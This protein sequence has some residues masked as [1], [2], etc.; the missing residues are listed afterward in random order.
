LIAPSIEEL[1]TKLAYRAKESVRLAGTDLLDE[2][3]H[4]YA[5]HAG[6]AVELLLRAVLAK[7]HPTLIA[8][9]TSNFDSLLIL[10]GQ[11]QYA[12]PQSRV[13]PSLAQHEKALRSLLDIRNGAIHYVDSES[14]VANNTLRGV[15]GLI[16]IVAPLLSV[17]SDEILVEYGE[18][19]AAHADALNSEAAK[20]ALRKLLAARSLY[21]I[22]FQNRAAVT[23]NEIEPLFRP[24]REAKGR[25]A[26]RCPACRHDGTLEYDVERELEIE[27]E[28]RTELVA[29]GIPARIERDN[30]D[31]AAV[32]PA[33]YAALFPDDDGGTH[34]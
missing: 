19:F 30:E 22:R 5:V 11:R 2:Q 13:A 12:S 15:F 26:R 3:W 34:S 10:V 24:F 20:R 7:L 28:T 32:D 29:A 6:G 4:H 17:T 33:Y 1:P 25:R 21:T 9:P 8:A 14:A 16:H 23:R 27:S 31:L 18:A